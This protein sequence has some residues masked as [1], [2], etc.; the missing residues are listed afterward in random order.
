MHICIEVQNSLM[1]LHDPSRRHLPTF[2]RGDPGNISWPRHKNPRSTATLFNVPSYFN[3]SGRQHTSVCVHVLLKCSESGPAPHCRDVSGFI[4]FWGALCHG[5]AVQ[6][7]GLPL[8]PL[9]FLQRNIHRLG[10]LALLDPPPTKPI[11]RDVFDLRPVH[12]LGK[13]VI[14]VS[15]HFCLV[16]NL[17]TAEL[18]VRILVVAHR[19]CCFLGTFVHSPSVVGEEI[20]PG[21][22]VIE[23]Q[24]VLT[25]VRPQPQ[26]EMK[27]PMRG[28]R[29][30]D[31]LCLSPHSV[32]VLEINPCS[33]LRVSP[34]W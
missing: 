17:A 22:R 19:V 28:W 4:L 15:T 26:Y 32:D 12:A 16:R 7:H 24:T 18:V 10:S 9:I 25:G 8:L 29:E 30:D 31:L 2:A 5:R 14:L 13:I 3:C 6:V 33:G 1:I 21:E 34:V 23:R 20:C 11:L 27:A